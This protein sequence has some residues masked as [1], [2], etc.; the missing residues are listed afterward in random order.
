VEGLITLEEYASNIQEKLNSASKY[1]DT[2]PFT[3]MSKGALDVYEPEYLNVYAKGALIGLS[4]DIMIRE[5]SNGQ[6][7]LQDVINKLLVKYGK[8]RS[9]KDEELF[10]EIEALTS[11]KVREFLDK[12]VAGPARIPYEDIYGKIGIEVK[13]NPYEAIN[14]GEISYG[15]NQSSYRLK[16]VKIEPSGGTFFKDLGIKEG[17]ELVSFNGQNITY[18]NSQ[19]IFGGAKNE[20]KKGDDF[21][22]V[23]VRNDAGGKEKKVTLKTKVPETKTSYDFILKIIDSPSDKQTQLQKAW[24]QK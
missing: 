20:I 7:G 8:D 13:K 18:Q 3:V 14:A 12:Y 6:Q 16:V 11:P 24:L 1:N 5:E 22:L 9:F 17:D 23:V 2:L 10:G 4:L 15:L 21:E 19:S